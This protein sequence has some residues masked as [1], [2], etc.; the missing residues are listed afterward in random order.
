MVMPVPKKEPPNRPTVSAARTSNG[1]VRVAWEAP[2]SS[3]GRPVTVAVSVSGVDG[4]PNGSTDRSGSA[5]VGTG[6]SQ[7]FGITVTVT[8][9]EGQASEA[10]ASASTRGKGTAR[11]RT[12]TRGVTCPSDINAPDGCNEYVIELQDWYPDTMVE[13]H[14]VSS[15]GNHHYP[16]MR[17]DGD[18][19]GWLRANMAY[20]IGWAGFTERGDISGDCYYD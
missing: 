11:E 1:R 3:N 7:S 8:N 5:T 2:S 13:C 15:K 18:G 16:R 14:V 12:G 9:S 6:P 20:A 4:S 10:S 19:Y 17:V